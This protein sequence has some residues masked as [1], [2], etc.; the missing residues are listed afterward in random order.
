MREKV[1]KI[2]G[3]MLYD[4]EGDLHSKCPL[5][6]ILSF[7]FHLKHYFPRSTSLTWARLSQVSFLCVSVGCVHYRV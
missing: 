4:A 2:P 6:K 1:T 3:E 5:D 7:R